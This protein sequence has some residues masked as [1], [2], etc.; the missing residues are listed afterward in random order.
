MKLSNRGIDQVRLAWCGGVAGGLLL[1]C[2]SAGAATLTDAGVSIDNEGPVLDSHADQAFLTRTTFYAGTALFTEAAASFG[3][4]PAM[5]AIVDAGVDRWGQAVASLS[6]TMTFTAA[7]TQRI[8]VYSN[9]G[10]TWSGGGR[11]GRQPVS[12][13]EVS[14]S[15]GQESYTAYT[16]P[17]G[18][19][20][21]HGVFTYAVDPDGP[22]WT[23]TTQQTGSYM[24]RRPWSVYT[25]VPYRFAFSVLAVAGDTG[26]AEINDPLWFDV[27]DAISISAASGASYLPPSPVPETGTWAMTAA[28]LLVLGVTGWRSTRRGG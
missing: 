10:G 12:R 1:A 2:G 26:R 21:V 19:Q 5:Y 7:D 25:N 8:T 15:L 4:R 3:V 28:G 13:V 9:V 6:D 20:S 11:G 27:P 17:A 16:Y 22:E 18:S 14:T 24:F 23:P